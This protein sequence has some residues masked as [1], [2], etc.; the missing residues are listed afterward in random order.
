MYICGHVVI[1]RLVIFLC[2]ICS[3]FMGRIESAG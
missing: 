2:G 1:L 3:I